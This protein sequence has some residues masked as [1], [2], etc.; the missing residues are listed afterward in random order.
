VSVVRARPQVGRAD[1]GS[2]GAEPVRELYDTYAALLDDGDYPAW[3]D[4]FVDEAS[5]MVI[6]RENVERGLPL[7]TI[8]CESRGMLA[9]RLDALTATQFYARRFTRHLVTAVRPVDTGDG[10][11]ATTANFVIVETVEGE[12]SMV[13]SA[14]GYRDRIVAREGELR[15]LE[16]TAVYDA[17]LVPT[18][19]IVPY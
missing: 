2:F 13:H 16:K 10:W 19:I 8:R 9:D 11:L 12:T 5:Y 14:G 18:S 7:A 15:F 3:L 17:A 4:L 1:W 6:A